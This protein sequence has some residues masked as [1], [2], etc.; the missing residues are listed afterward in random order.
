MAEFECV[1]FFPPRLKLICAVCKR[2]SIDE[3]CA[4]GDFKAYSAQKI[5]LAHVSSYD[6]LKSRYEIFKKNCA[7]RNRYVWLALLECVKFE[8]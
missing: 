8:L 6:V 4:G 5:Y 2:N 3:H 1:L 7:K